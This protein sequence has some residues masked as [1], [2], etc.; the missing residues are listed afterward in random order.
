[1]LVTTSHTNLKNIQ[2]STKN[3]KKLGLNTDIEK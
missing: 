2:I 3:K 1:M